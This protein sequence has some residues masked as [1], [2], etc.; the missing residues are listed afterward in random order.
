MSV[1]ARR[2]SPGDPPRRPPPAGPGIIGPWLLAKPSRGATVRLL[3]I[4]LFLPALLAGLQAQAQAAKCLYVSSYHR[5]YEW[6]DGIE[7]GLESS[8][9]GRCELDRFYMDTKR[10]T[11]PQHGSDMARRAHDWISASRPDVVIACD[12]NASKYLVAPYLKDSQ[13]P[14]VFCG[15]N[16]TVESYGYPY[17]NAT[18][19]I[20]VAPIRPLLKEIRGVFP[21]V[22]QGIYLSSEVYTEH[23]DFERYRRLYAAEGVALRGIFVKTLEE[24]KAGY[25]DAQRQGVDFIVLGNNAGI[26]DWD[27][28]QAA[29]FALLHAK[30]FSVTN[31]DWMM[32]YTM[33]AMTKLPEEQGEW[34]GQVAVAVLDGVPVATIPVV[35]NRR[36]NIYISPVLLER[37]G[38]TLPLGLTQSAIKVGDY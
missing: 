11:D 10:I 2:A 28:K 6:N 29:D 20:E 9:A 15:I 35:V 3:C 1:P 19:M 30:V 7:Q 18:G 24:W 26:N 31:Y 4:G 34:A 17:A 13:V 16:W 25:L 23:K 22:S 21:A 36:W 5:G 38:I 33:F 14:V 12:D 32:P 27:R 8:L 37:A